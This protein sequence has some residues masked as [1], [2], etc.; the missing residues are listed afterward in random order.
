MGMA[1]TNIMKRRRRSLAAGT[2]LLPYFSLAVVYVHSK[3]FYS[4]YCC[5]SVLTEKLKFFE[6]LL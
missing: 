5:A 4:Y 1:I 2:G 3:F 6:I